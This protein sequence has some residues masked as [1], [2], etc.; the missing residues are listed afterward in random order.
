[1]L[2]SSLELPES[3]S[4]KRR[5]RSCSVVSATF[6]S[7]VPLLSLMSSTCRGRQASHPRSDSLTSRNKR[8]L[9][10]AC[11]LPQM[12]PSHGVQLAAL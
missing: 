5:L 9:C 8:L 12:S 10:L 1:M 6:T 7:M 11:L 3:L 2:P 4:M